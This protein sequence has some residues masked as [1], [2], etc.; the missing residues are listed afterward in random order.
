MGLKRVVVANSPSTQAKY[1]IFLVLARGTNYS[2]LMWEL[3]RE[4]TGQPTDDD[5]ADQMY[6]TLVS[7]SSGA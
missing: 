4:W 5:D 3:L 7:A 6:Q 2:F 1:P